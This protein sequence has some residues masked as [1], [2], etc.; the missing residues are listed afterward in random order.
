MNLVNFMKLLTF[1]S[2]NW[3]VV[4]AVGGGVAALIIVWKCLKAYKQKPRLKEQK[5]V[6]DELK[7]LLDKLKPLLEKLKPLLDEL[8]P[9]LEEPKP[10]I[11]ERRPRVKEPKPRLEEQKP[12]LDKSKPLLDKQKPRLKEQRPVLD[13][14]KLGLE[15]YERRRGVYN[16]VEKIL[17]QISSYGDV[18]INDLSKFKSAVAGTD[19][20]FG[21]EIREYVDEIYSHGLGLSQANSVFRIKTPQQ[22]EGYDHN[23]AVKEQ[24]EQLDWLKAQLSGVR[25]KFN[26]YLDPN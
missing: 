18:S 2:E 4:S 25:T 20:L 9:L 14:Q 13:K 17:R 3:K 19:S 8:T 7:P 21:P 16:E 22:S 15:I 1:L 6:L 12:V 24:R 11:D 5:P 26:K 23:K 10:R